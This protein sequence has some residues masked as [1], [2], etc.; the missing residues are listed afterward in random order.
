[1]GASTCACATTPG[2][3][4]ALLGENYLKVKYGW[5]DLITMVR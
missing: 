3:A 1:M 4:S 2:A 5:Q